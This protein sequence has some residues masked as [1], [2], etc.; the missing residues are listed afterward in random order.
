MSETLGLISEENRLLTRG[1]RTIFALG[2]GGG[3]SGIAVIRISGPESR[4]VLS[5]F[6]G[7]REPLPR[8]ASR[9]K[10]RKPNGEVLDDG[11]VIWFPGPASFTGEDLVEFHVHGG[12]ATINAIL[13]ALG[14]MD[15]LFLAEPGEFTRRAFENGKLDLTGVEA[16]SDLIAAETDAQRRQALRQL[17]GVFGQKCDE[18]REKLISTLAYL[19]AWIDFPD[20]DLPDTLFEET[21]HNILE[22]KDSITQ[23]IDDNRIGERIRNGVSVAILGPPNSGKSSFLNFL[24]G[25]EAAIVS[26]LAGTTRDIIEVRSEIG[27]LAVTFSDSA[28][29][30]DAQDEIEAEGVRRAKS[31]AATADFCIFLEAPDTGKIDTMATL[32]EAG[33]TVQEALFIRNKADLDQAKNVSGLSM[34]LKTGENCEI[35]LG[36]LEKRFTEKFPVSASAPVTRRRHREALENCVHHLV[37]AG[38]GFE[39]ELIAEDIRCAVRALGRITG[40][41]DVEDILD[42][43]FREFCI[44]K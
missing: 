2:S 25:R 9:R 41:V 18:W 37:Q 11:L 32:L 42:R 3:I 36:E 26:S 33:K 35:I 30:R 5:S 23:Y 29:L 22:L 44:G 39:I 28:G 19:E 13:D 34:S 40:R 14:A 6:V 12:L 38:V 7:G 15:G 8:L 1:S 31:L 10:L 43:L 4:S 16:L 20:E 27:G 17:D 21:K 24:A